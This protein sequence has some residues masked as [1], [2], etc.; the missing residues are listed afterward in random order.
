M[1]AAWVGVVG[2]LGGVVVGA[3]AEGLRARAAFKREKHWTV[4]EQLR[5][6]LEM[7][8]EA[9]EQLRQSY[10]EGVAQTSYVM[11]FGKQPTTQRPT[12]EAPWARLRML[13]HLY[14][15]WLTTHLEAVEATGR[16]VGAS[17]GKAIVAQKGDLAHDEPYVE[18]MFDAM[19]PLDAAINKMRDEIV[20]STRRLDQATLSEIGTGAPTVVAGA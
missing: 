12:L 11:R 7:V 18:R 1:D 15:P 13:V 5:Q 9:L 20:A 4:R 8:Y 3:L 19:R 2:A 10:G 14:T 17:M 6:R 16:A